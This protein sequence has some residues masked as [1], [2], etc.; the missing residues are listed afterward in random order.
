MNT[1]QFKTKEQKEIERLESALLEK[2]SELTQVKKDR[3]RLNYAVERLEN[4]IIEFETISKDNSLLAIDNNQR[5]EELKEEIQTINSVNNE[6]NEQKDKL[7][8]NL[9]QKVQNWE[10]RYND[11]SK[12]YDNIRESVKAEYDGYVKKELDKIVNFRK[13]LAPDKYN[14]S[15][16][17]DGEFYYSYVDFNVPFEERHS[18]KLPIFSIKDCIIQIHPETGNPLTKW[19]FE[20]IEEWKEYNFDYEARICSYR[21]Y[22]HTPN[23]PRPESQLIKAAHTVGMQILPFYKH[24]LF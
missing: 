10:Y 8:S 17:K 20:M 5:I 11:L 3:K 23:G 7:I 18:I 24:L 12:S 21:D 15:M 19:H 13:V 9:E 14:L 22:I 6:K 1:K 4:K 2:Q 16:F